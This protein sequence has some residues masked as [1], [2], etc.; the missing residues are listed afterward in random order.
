M[1]AGIVTTDENVAIPFTGDGLNRHAQKADKHPDP[2]NN[3]SIRHDNGRLMLCKLTSSQVLL[4][5][6]DASIQACYEGEH[7]GSNEED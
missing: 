1:G 3:V 2:S 4:T 7:E 5:S 6:P